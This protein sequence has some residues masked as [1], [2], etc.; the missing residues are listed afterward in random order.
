MREKLSQKE[1]LNEGFLD[2]IRKIT[3]P[4][5]K[6]VAGAAGAA[7]GIA[8]VVAPNLSQA[9]GSDINKLKSIGKS[10][11]DAFTAEKNRQINS[12]PERFVENELKTKWNNT[13][14]PNSIKITSSQKEEIGETS[15]ARHSEET[16]RTFVYFEASKYNKTTGNSTQQIGGVTQL[17]GVATVIKGSDGK[18]NIIEIKDEDGNAINQGTQQTLPSLND[19]M[20]KLNFNINNSTAGKWAVA[21]KR[22]FRNALPD[23]RKDIDKL[24][25]A[26]VNDDNYVLTSADVTILRQYLKDEMLIS[27]KNTQ[28]DLLVQLKLLND[29][30]NKTYELSKH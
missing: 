20:N 4:I 11:S 23:P 2:T 8:K 29:S 14:N 10:A 30:Y 21:L 26:A 9:I 17:K 25:P 18:F 15:V 28:K 12:T 13:F 22:S 3:S 16:P 7:K 1:L 6:T 19:L 24:I 5:A 27:E